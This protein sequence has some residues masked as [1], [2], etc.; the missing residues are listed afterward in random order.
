MIV[1]S[2]GIRSSIDRSYSSYP[3][4]VRLSSP[5]LSLISMI[6]FFTTESN[7]FLSAKIALYSAIFFS[8][9]AYSL[10]SFSLSKPV[11]ARKR[12]STIAFA[13]ASDKENLCCNFSFASLAFF[14]PRMI[15]I[16]SSM[17]SNA[18]NKPSKICALSSA[19]FKSYFVRR[20]TTSS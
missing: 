7:T 13:C 20:V 8:N 6:S 19:L 18:T 12:I 3:I 14:D 10:S 4:E 2:F 16:T 17:L 9:S 15:W 5:Y 11:N 1:F